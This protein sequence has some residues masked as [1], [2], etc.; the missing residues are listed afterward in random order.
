MPEGLP[1]PEKSIFDI[2]KEQL[3]E[4]KKKADN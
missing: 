3:A 1:A 4:L 2:E